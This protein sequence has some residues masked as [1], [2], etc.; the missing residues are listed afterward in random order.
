[1]PHSN[2]LKTSLFLSCHPNPLHHP[3]LTIIN[4]IRPLMTKS[5]NLVIDSLVV[6]YFPF[7][8][9]LF[10]CTEDIFPASGHSHPPCHVTFQYCADSPDQ[11]LQLIKQ[12]LNR[13]MIIKI[14]GCNNITQRLSLIHKSTP[15]PDKQVLQAMV[16]SPKLK[17]INCGIRN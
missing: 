9:H 15:Y 5:L 10:H 2:T 17:V 4:T 14:I 7:T 3:Q 13:G 11:V 8:P 1:M 16:P 6:D 12:C